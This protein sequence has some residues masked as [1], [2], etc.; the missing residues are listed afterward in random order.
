MRK[1]FTAIK[2]ND[3]DE[4]NNII[5]KNP[6]LVNCAAKQPPKKDD[7][8]SPLQV[9]LK[10]GNF[11]IADYLIDM[12]AD[13]NY[14]ED[15]ACCNPW[16]APV[17]HDA[18]NAAVM[19]S[20]W[21]T[22][23]PYTGF[24]VFSTEQQAETAFHV[25]KRMI[26]AGADLNKLDSYGNSAIWRFCAQATQILPAYNFQEHYEKDNRIFTP[27][28]EE[29]LTRILKLLC[30]HG[31]DLNYKAPNFNVT[32]KEFYNYGSIAKLLAKVED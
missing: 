1:L 2:H 5:S 16:R 32:V 8:Q 27:E 10:N 11:E 15:T 19:C 28:L 7:G 23:N 13:L 22:N 29:D 24:E 9:A 14:M 30:E 25:L 17:V 20:R 31:A 21:N 18:I 6:E 26:I 12:G 4:V 3:I